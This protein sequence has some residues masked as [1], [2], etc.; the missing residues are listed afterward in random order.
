MHDQKRRIAG[1]RE[2]HVNQL[3]CA[4]RLKARGRHNPKAHP[5]NSKRHSLRNTYEPHIVNLRKLEHGFRMI[6]AGIPLYLTLRA[7][8]E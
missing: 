2:G 6:I 4:S 5:Q 7:G 1:R 8:G 3:A